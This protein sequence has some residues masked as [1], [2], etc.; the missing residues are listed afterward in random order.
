M[1]KKSFILIY[2]ASIY[3]TTPI[4]ITTP[5]TMIKINS[6]SDCK[7][8]SDFELSLS[9]VSVIDDNDGGCDGDHVGSW[10][11]AVGSIVIIE[12]SVGDRL[13]G[14]VAVFNIDSDGGT[15]GL[16]EGNLLGLNVGCLLGFCEGYSLGLCNGDLLG[17]IV[18]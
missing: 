8:S 9:G 3:P 4:T 7:L 12:A 13:G 6:N 15:E 14:S 11:A 10:V 16:C 1:E 17:L 18:G 2:F 5:K